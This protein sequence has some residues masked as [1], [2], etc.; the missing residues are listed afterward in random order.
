M[1]VHNF[2]RS[3][4]YSHELANAPWWET[5]YRRA[6]PDMVSMVDLRHDG[7]HQRAG[8]D[9]AIILS[10]GRAIYIDEKGRS[11]SYDDI[12]VEIWSVYPTNGV[13]PFPPVPGAEPGWARKL[14]DCDWLAYAFVPTGVCHLLP[15]LGIRAAFE[16]HRRTWLDS[17][18]RGANGF[19]WVVARNGRYNTIS[20]AVP[21]WIL[22]DAMADA[23]TVAWLEGAA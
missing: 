20:I 18:N 9:R 7:W 17:A 11:E 21:L 23:M 5:V 22:R 3:L 13:A 10:S 8:R 1:T 15:F 4:D 12:A 2:R 19:R 16:K 14:L 6:F